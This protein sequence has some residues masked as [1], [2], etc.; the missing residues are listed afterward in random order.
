MK[1]LIYAM[2]AIIS[3]SS[4]A[5]DVTI[6]TNGDEFLTS[7]KVMCAYVNGNTRSYSEA[8][9]FEVIEESVDIDLGVINVV[10]QACSHAVLTIHTKEIIND[11]PLS[12]SYRLELDTERKLALLESNELFLKQTDNSIDEDSANLSEHIEAGVNR[13]GEIIGAGLYLLRNPDFK[14]IP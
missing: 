2:L 5:H 3:L 12:R 7:A 1:N 13:I 11:I 6:N 9:E 4:M 10:D 8:G 14:G